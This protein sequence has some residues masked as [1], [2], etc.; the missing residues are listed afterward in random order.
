MAV[1]G[2]KLPF[3]FADFGLIEW[4]LSVRSDVQSRAIQTRSK[5]MQEWLWDFRLTAPKLAFA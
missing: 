3:K 4:P 5:S 2:R 1:F